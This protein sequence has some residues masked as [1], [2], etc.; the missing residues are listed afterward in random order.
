[1][2]K[3]SEF[4]KEQDSKGT[5]V[6]ARL[7]QESKDDLYKWAASSGIPN[8]I[9]P[10]E[11]H[12]TVCY[13]RKWFDPGYKSKNVS[14]SGNVIGYDLFKNSNGTT[15]FVLKLKSQELIDY[16]N[17]YRNDYGATHDYPEY[18]PHLTISY[19]VPNNFKSPKTPILTIR[20]DKL[21]VEELDLDWISKVKTI[22]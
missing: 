4:L 19:D 6:S 8:T 1:M 12:V 16:H 18:I 15:A 11:Y 14:L 20:F 5:Y 9:M 7:T 2:I 13:S 10:D 22:K 21:V 17:S 3:F